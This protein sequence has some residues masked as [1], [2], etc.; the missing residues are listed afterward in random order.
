MEGI[1]FCTERKEFGEWNLNLELYSYFS[2][3]LNTDKEL[4][5]LSKFNK[6]KK[7]KKKNPQQTTP[8]ISC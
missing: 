3:Q 7:K 8:L 4:T 2:A 1:F 6:K 5:E